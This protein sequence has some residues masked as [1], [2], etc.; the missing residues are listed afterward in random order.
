MAAQSTFLQT[1]YPLSE[2]SNP[3]HLTLREQAR[4]AQGGPGA[5]AKG[6]PTVRK[7]I[8]FQTWLSILL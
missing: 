3:D 4:V 5:G 7:E 8:P 1:P 6:D 2:G